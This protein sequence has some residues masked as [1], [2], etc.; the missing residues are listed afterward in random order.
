MRLK[1]ISHRDHTGYAQAAAALVNAL[2]CTGLQVLW[3]AIQQ[4]A[5]VPPPA[6]WRPD[7]VIVHTV[8]EHFAS[9]AQRE[10]A[11]GAGLVIG[12]TVW[13]T[14]RLPAHWPALINGMDAVIVPTEWNRDVFRQSGVTVPILVTP[15]VPQALQ[16]AL[17][18]DVRFMRQRFPALAGRLV[19]YSIGAWQQRKGMDRLVAAFCD[20]FSANDP[21]ALLIK[22]T[23]FD[24]DRSLRESG[25]PQHIPSHQQLAALVQQAQAH[26]GHAVA[27]IQLLTEDLSEADVQA[28]HALGDCF[29]S[30]NRGEGWGLG[31]FDAARLGKPIVTTG[32]G[33]PLAF[34]DAQSAHL[35][36]ARLVPV[37]MDVPGTSYRPDQHWAEPSHAD[38]VAALRAVLTQPADAA[39]RGLRA[40]QR[41]QA[42]FQPVAIARHLIAQLQHLLQRAE[43][44]PQ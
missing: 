32:W 28:V 8:P 43:G 18:Q 37:N 4:A 27:P 6:V 17:P 12:H 13:E 10:R 7:A 34:L 39:A 9:E 33:G 22:S 11:A 23:P 5:Q 1:Y 16:P 36:P 14:D 15:H 31:A 41:I 40:A 38:A 25:A 3:T 20:A 19:F 26:A 44:L 35:V 29:V 30:L 21:V 42:Q 24:Q 2:Q